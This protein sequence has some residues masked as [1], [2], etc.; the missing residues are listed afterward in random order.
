MV[1]LCTACFWELQKKKNGTCSAK[2]NTCS[3]RAGHNVQAIFYCAYDCSYNCWLFCW[4][5]CLL[6]L[7][8]YLW[9][10]CWLSCLLSVFMNAHFFLYFLFIYNSTYF[11][12]SD[13]LF[14]HFNDC[15]V[16]CIVAGHNLNYW[17]DVS[18]LKDQTYTGTALS[19]N[20]VVGIG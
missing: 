19:R 16:V 12:L 5:S 8:L 20:H 1:R 15:L 6:H 2:S 11:T 14:Q 3:V 4:M 18:C 13:F 10:V 7:W 9:Q 17:H